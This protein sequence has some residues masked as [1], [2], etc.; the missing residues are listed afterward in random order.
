MLYLWVKSFHLIF[1][2]AWMA[3]LLI[4]PRYKLHQLT[5]KPGEP[6]FETMKSASAKLRKIILTP[7]II[8]VWVLGISLIVINPAIMS[9]G[10]LHAKLL[11]VLL[12]SGLHGYFVAMGKKIDRGEDVPAKRLKMLNEV[13]FILLIIIVVLVIVKPF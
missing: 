13:P 12:L 9:G 3:G 8:L 1:V 6:L 5:S 2:I 7:S 4:L 10:W 11:L